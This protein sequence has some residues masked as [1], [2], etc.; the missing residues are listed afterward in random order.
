MEK[1]KKSATETLRDARDYVVE[2]YQEVAVLTM[3]S[4]AVSHEVGYLLRSIKMR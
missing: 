4:L 2:H 3:L 1:M